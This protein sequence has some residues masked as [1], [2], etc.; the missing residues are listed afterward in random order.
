MQNKSTH[1]KLSKFGG[2]AFIIGVIISLLLGVFSNFGGDELRA[3][4]VSGLIIMGLV[5]GFL[6][7]TANETQPFLLATVSLVIVAGLGSSVLSDIK[8]VGPALSHTLG[9]VM[10]F[11][12]PA[13]LVVALKAVY[14][15]AHDE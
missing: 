1:S 5:V 10:I 9:S 2:W 3:L 11:I 4:L 6:N 14:A 13:V 7:V 8:I 15:I 12:I